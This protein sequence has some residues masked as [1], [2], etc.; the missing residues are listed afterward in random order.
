MWVCKK[1]L[2]KE[3]CS[4][5]PTVSLSTALT[6]GIGQRAGGRI[7][8]TKHCHPLQHC[9]LAIKLNT[10][11]YVNFLLCALLHVV[12]RRKRRYIYFLIQF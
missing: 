12:A 5:S 2:L 8:C 6:G 10:S 11:V 4:S 3:L 9:N 7:M 1:L